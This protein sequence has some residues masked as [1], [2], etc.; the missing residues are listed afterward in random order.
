MKNFD[1]ADYGQSAI[2]AN[3]VHNRLPENVT[4]VGT[5]ADINNYWL[6]PILV[7][8]MLTAALNFLPRFRIFTGGPLNPMGIIF[9]KIHIYCTYKQ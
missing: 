4:P 9:P 1:E 6:F 3:Y 8:S 5:R 2:R 7:V